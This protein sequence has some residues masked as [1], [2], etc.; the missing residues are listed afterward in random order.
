M[1]RD[2]FEQVKEINA[3][4]EKM[5][6][7]HTNVKLAILAQAIM[8]IHLEEAQ[9]AQSQSAGS[10]PDMGTAG[11]GPTEASSPTTT[12]SQWDAAELASTPLETRALLRLGRHVI[13]SGHAE[14]CF[15]C[16]GLADAWR[17][18]VQ[19]PAPDAPPITST[20]QR[21]DL[22]SFAEAIADDAASR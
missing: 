2:Y 18:A 17:L 5:E 19:T 10:S 13:A 15:K 3:Q 16:A 21:R 1:D 4:T 20:S 8:R 11:S 12:D 7:V 9:Q 14:R 6:R 22:R